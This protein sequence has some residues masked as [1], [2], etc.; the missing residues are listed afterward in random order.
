ME[1]PFIDRAALAEA[2]ANSIIRNSSGQADD[3]INLALWGLVDDLD[4]HLEVD[5]IIQDRFQAEVL[6][7]RFDG[8]R[9]RWGHD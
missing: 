6:E 3:G 1:T 5:S 9:A 2:L 8:A 4:L 7:A